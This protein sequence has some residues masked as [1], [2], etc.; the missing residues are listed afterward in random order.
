M[1]PIAS[2]L[3]KFVGRFC[4]YLALLVIAAGVASAGTYTIP[5]GSG[6][7]TY[8]ETTTSVAC[9]Y[10]DINHIVNS[11]DSH[12]TYTNFSYTVSG[13][14]TPLSGGTT[15]DVG[16]G[17]GSCINLK[18]AVWL[19]STFIDVYFTPAEP[20]G[21]SVSSFGYPGYVNPKY[22]ILGVTYA[23]PGPS[24]FVDYTD[25]TLVADQTSLSSSFSS[26]Y[27]VTISVKGGISGWLNGSVTG[28]SSTTYTQASNSSSSVT[29]SKTTSESDKTPGPANAYAGVDHDYDVIWLWL[30]PVS[31]FTV[32]ESTAGSVTSLTWTGYGYTTADQPNMDVYPVYVGWLNGDIAIPPSVQTVLD[33]TWAA[34]EIWPSGQGPGLTTTDFETIEAADPYWDCQ[35]KP[36]SCPTTVSGTRFTGPIS[37]E[38]FVYVQAPVGGEPL[39][40][41]YTLT[42]A[43]TT[44]QG[45]GATYTF[46][47]M[48]G[49]EEDFGAKV[50][51]IGLTATLK[52]SSTFTWVSQWNNQI[53]NSD[54]LTAELS[55]TGPPCVVSGSVCNP[56]YTGANEFDVYQ[57]NLYGTFLFIPTD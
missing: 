25:S 8:T 46:S 7:L 3:S 57:D 36:T 41:T 20:T 24:S 50:F 2:S 12:Y 56:V 30:N 29:V 34:N 14:T 38:D 5:A 43:T 37:G 35:P 31:L 44:T 28:T 40:Q 45:E 42:D 48:F 9:S 21:G 15:V 13:V 53:T 39:T 4:L 55:I 16:N 51:G 32:Y 18:L 6:T 54:T 27:N 19:T 11:T 47:Q 1:K 52:E 22:V 10:F 17:E 33:R 23:P 49:M 26:S